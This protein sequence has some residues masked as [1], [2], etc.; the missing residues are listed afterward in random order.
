[1]LENTSITMKEH[2]SYSQNNSGR[3]RIRNTLALTAV[4]LA[5]Q[6][7]SSECFNGLQ[8]LSSSSFSHATKSTSS[9]SF[10]QQGESP[11]AFFNN[12][13]FATHTSLID[14]SRHT[15]PIWL[16]FDNS[17]LRETNM[18]SLQVFMQN[19]FFTDRETRQLTD[20]I[21][22]AAEGDSSMIA[23]AAE[24]CLLLAETMEMRIDSLIAGA[25]HYCSCVIAREQAVTSNLYNKNS[26]ILNS[27]TLTHHWNLKSYGSQVVDIEADAARLKQ[28]ELVAA[29]VFSLSEG[30]T[31]K[32]TPDSRDAKNLQHLLLTETK[33][34]R[35][36]AIRSAACLY[37][38]NG[39][40]K[41][42][43]S[44][45]TREVVRTAREALSIYAPLASKMGMHRLKNELEGAAFR[46]LYRRQYE[47]VTSMNNRKITGSSDQVNENN[48]AESLNHV[49]EN[50]K[51]D[52][53]RILQKDSEFQS[54]VRNFSITARVKEPYSMWKKMLRL[55]CDHVLQVPDALAL[56][57]VLTG[58]KLSLDEPNEVTQA[59]ERVLCYYARELLQKHYQPVRE[60][61]RFKDYIANPK[62]NGYQSL[63]YTANTCWEG[64]TWTFEVQ[65][66]SSEMH[67]VAEFGLASHSDYKAENKRNPVS[68]T[69]HDKSE[70]TETDKSSE[71]YR[72]NIQEWQWQQ[73]G[74]KMQIDLEKD[75]VPSHDMWHSRARD[76]WIRARTERLKPYLQSLT[77]TQSDLARDHV[78]VF[79]A[80]EL[81]NSDDNGCSIAAEGKVLA[82][83]AGSCVLDALRESEQTLG[84][85]YLRNQG[86]AVNGKET[87]VTR[88]LQNGDIL[89]IQCSA[90]SVV[91][92]L[93]KSFE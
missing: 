88:L 76:N 64:E 30:R 68:S 69:I 39:I 41:A 17:H 16:S 56:R 10:R 15:L 50:V 35:A 84:M 55:G 80:Q 90:R 18:Q 53:T 42:N 49:L 45:L 85:S 82:L 66:R 51:A 79:L 40:L 71:A 25:F 86:F 60:N 21:E 46:I 4:I 8:Y 5:H 73:H 20:A 57:V 72:R 22:E 47:A 75:S 19:S 9:L 29:S 33:D 83:P 62:K 74:S 91:L 61:P 6:V 93:I 65:V 24:F 23:G 3:R 59:R 1:M 34:W 92:A 28:L 11:V 89:G 58:K 63:H 26:N 14:T 70:D 43:K 37:R 77:N 38:L 48:I 44:G 87:T 32:V 67:S 54:Q 12:E 78:F 27:N 52:M 13:R 2:V 36:L 81:D 7:T 31:G